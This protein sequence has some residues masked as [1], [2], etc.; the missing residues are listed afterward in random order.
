MRVVYRLEIENKS[1]WFLSVIFSVLSVFLKLQ[2][3]KTCDNFD[4]TK[5]DRNVHNLTKVTCTTLI[6][7]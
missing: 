1:N 3:L 7:Y 2:L 6:S 5:S 4:K